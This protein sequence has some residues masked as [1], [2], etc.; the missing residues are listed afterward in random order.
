MEIKTIPFSDLLKQEL[1]EFVDNIIAVVEKHDPEALK[2]EEVF[3][4]LVAQRPNLD[5]LTQPYGAHSVT[6]LLTPL[7]KNRLLFA[8]RIVYN[9]NAVMKENRGKHTSSMLEASIEINRYLHRLD[10][11]K[12]EVMVVKRI[13]GFFVELITNPNLAIAT[14][15]AGL[16]LDCNRLK[17]VHSEINELLLERGGSISERSSLTKKELSNPIIV[18][19]KDFFMQVRVAEVK[20]ASLNYLPLISELNKVVTHYRNLIKLRKSTNKRKALGLEVEE[21]NNESTNTEVESTPLMKMMGTDTA[22]VN[23]FENRFEEQLDQKKTVAS[24]GKHL[25]LPSVNNNEA[26]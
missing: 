26:D 19:T 14:E 5:L 7:R 23:G 11:C 22:N 21:S 20:N 13:R 3:N 18:A 1:P 24:S 15:A 4:L 9:M 16:T 10:L 8:Q 12:N 17:Q 25:Q 2:I 6:A